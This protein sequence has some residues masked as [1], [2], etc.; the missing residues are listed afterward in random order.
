MSGPTVARD[1]VA[2]TNRRSGNGLSCS[3]STAWNTANG[4][5]P[6][7]GRQQRLPA[8]FTHHSS[9]A[10]CICATDVNSRPRQNESRI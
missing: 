3:A 1:Q 9:A 6:P 8:T 4:A 7:N 10:C 2:S 5:A